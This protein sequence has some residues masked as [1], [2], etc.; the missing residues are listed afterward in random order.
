MPFS[1][2]ENCVFSSRIDSLSL[3]S[4][5]ALAWAEQSPLSLRPS[6][7]GWLTG[8]MFC[9]VLSAFS[10]SFSYLVPIK[11]K[12]FIKNFCPQREGLDEHYIDSTFDSTRY[13][14]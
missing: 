5:L 10:V 4:L 12:V 9:P 11:M 8:T 14:F 3:G 7:S 1:F 2:L 6:V 13:V